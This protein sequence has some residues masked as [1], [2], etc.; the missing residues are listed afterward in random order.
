MQKQLIKFT[1]IFLM[2][3]PGIASAQLYDTLC[4]KED[5]DFYTENIVFNNYKLCTLSPNED[6]NIFGDGVS[7]I[8][9]GYID[10]YLATKDKAY[11][12]KFVHQSLCIIEN[13]N[14]INPEA[15]VKTPK[16]S[17][18][19]SSTYVDG[20]VI[21]S[22]ARFVH[23]IK[24][25]EPELMDVEL[26]QFDELNPDLYEPNTCNCNYTGIRFKTFG[27]YAQWLEDRV[28]ETLDYFVYGGFWDY[29]T[30]MQ[31]PGGELIINMQ[32]GFARCLLFTGLSSTNKE[33]LRMADTI[34]SLHKSMVSFSDRCTK[35][36]YK[37]P[38]FRLNKDNN[39]YWWYHAG[40]RLSY[41]ECARSLFL[42]EP[43][44]NSFTEYVEDVS[45]GTIV[46][47]FPY[48][49]Y[50]YGTGKFFT[51]SDMIRFRNTFV[52]NIYENGKYNI[53]ID[54]SNGTT[55]P[56]S[57]YNAEQINTI[58]QTCSLGFA[59]WAD[60]DFEPISSEPQ[61]YNIV[62]NDYIK[63]LHNMSEVPK[64][65]GGQKSMG[66]AQIVAQQWKRETYNLS[67]YNRDMVYNQDF[68]APGKIVIEPKYSRPKIAGSK[69]PY[70]HPKA[71]TDSGSLDRFVI[72]PGVEVNISAK[73]SVRIKQGFYA[74][75]GSELKV[76]LVKD[77]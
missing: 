34:A 75:K 54:G 30:G 37:A 74:K 6:W 24:V 38:V 68:Y 45:H 59:N 40:W 25:L 58:R 63:L 31:Q 65:Y 48:E 28:R 32:T 53:G 73:E 36:K 17:E 62:M 19:T 2:S 49:Y 3:L 70:A 20:Y 64:W 33:Y 52:Y 56:E 39:S 76:S 4:I 57:K 46:M 72:E 71:F 7:K 41:R 29:K 15:T 22:L 13:R 60:F 1:L 69:K 14:D 50:K 21:G 16:W 43:N 66:H 26:Y 67:L 9:D 27:E 11:L 12:Y 35:K 10:V 51:A 44:F 18:S 5:Y 77:E 23:L 42:K 55:Y 8:I 47:T 61:V